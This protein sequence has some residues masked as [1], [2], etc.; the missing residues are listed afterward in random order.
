MLRQMLTERRAAI[1]PESLGLIR[2]DPRGRKS[3]GLTQAHVDHLLLRA[4][5][6]YGKL[7]RGVLD[8]PTPEYLRDVAHLL[9]LTEQEWVVLYSYA[10]G[11]Q[12]PYPLTMNPEVT[13]PGHWMRIMHAFSGIAYLCDPQWNV[14]AYNEAFAAIFPG[15]RPPCNTMHWMLFNKDARD[16]VLT[17]WETRWAA[18]VAPQLRV[19]LARNPDNRTLRT[20]SQQCLA[21]PRTRKYFRSVAPGHAHPDGAERPLH[22]SELGPGSLTISV[23]EPVGTQG[24]LLYQLLFRPVGVEWPDALPEIRPRAVDDPARFFAAFSTTAREQPVHDDQTPWQAVVKK[25]G[26]KA[27]SSPLAFASGGSS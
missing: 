5:G 14:L 20:L 1:S 8:S 27:T 24:T 9:G 12:P 22:H 16:R 18:V 3:P 7:E 4:P 13:V 15:R 2:L 10:R 6:T 23:S 21:D 19:A 25:P 17:D 11:E 26:P